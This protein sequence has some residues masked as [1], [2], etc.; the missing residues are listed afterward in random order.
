MKFNS[1]DRTEM[2]K[3]R[4]SKEE[5][6]LIRAKAEM[7]GYRYLSNYIRDSAIYEKVTQ[8]DL[9]GQDE[10]LSAFS[11]N[12]KEI[13]EIAKGVRH[14]CKFLTQ[15]DDLAMA[16]LRA[17]M[18]DIMRAQYKI[19]D[20]ITKKLDLGNPRFEDFI[21]NRIS[22]KILSDE[23]YKKELLRFIKTFD[24][25]IE[26][27][28]TTP[29]SIE[30][31]QNNNR[32]VKV[33]LIHRGEDNKLKALP[34]DLES[35]GTRKMFHLFDFLMDALKNGMVL[36]IDE[37][38]AKLHPLLT[39][40]IINLFHNSET[41]IGKGQLIYSTHDTVN[42]NKDTFRRDEIWFT[43]KNRDGVSEI[44]ALSDYIL[45]DDEDSKNKTSKKV[46]NDATYN[47]DY[48]TGRYGAIPVLEKFEINY[49]K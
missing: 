43:E 44:Y 16:N 22:L 46:R 10:I 23:K 25:G 8:V 11:E 15:A 2:L 36:F 48:L 6:T 24:S 34:I 30:E 45:E 40:Y 21:N 19:C 49:E 35:N 47:K 12:T 41:N 3:I 31:I 29:D 4:V 7:Y 13:K 38:D 26:G 27:I 37:L 17:R 14:L 18:Y 39:R 9:K 20:L 5:K 28:K 33:E 32:V 42:L 1:K